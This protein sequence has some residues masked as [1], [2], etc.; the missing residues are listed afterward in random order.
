MSV[1]NHKSFEMK[2]PSPLE[3][4]FRKMD[5]EDQLIIENDIFNSAE[6][7]PMENALSAI[8]DL[9]EA[10]IMMQQFSRYIK[11]RGLLSREQRLLRAT[12]INEFIDRRI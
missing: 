7:I 12:E 10:R 8:T 6:A 5:T 4:F 1:E 3:N 9:E 2:E 11:D